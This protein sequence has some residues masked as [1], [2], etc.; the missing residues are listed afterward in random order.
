[1]DQ[2]KKFVKSHEG[3]L[4]WYNGAIVHHISSLY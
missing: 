2:V 3:L 1:V 4:F